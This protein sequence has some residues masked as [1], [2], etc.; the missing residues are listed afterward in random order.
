MRF[1]ASI[2]DADRQIASQADSV[3]LVCSAIIA[4]GESVLT[5]S[6]AAQLIAPGAGQPDLLAAGPGVC[7]VDYPSWRREQAGQFK[8]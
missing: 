5:K 6:F 3:T 1:S 2:E 8:T 7:A 4:S